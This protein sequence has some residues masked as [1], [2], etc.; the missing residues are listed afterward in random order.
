[1]LRQTAMVT[2]DCYNPLFGKRF[3]ALAFL[4][5]VLNRADGLPTASRH[6][7]VGVLRH[8]ESN[9]VE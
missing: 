2:R 1:M 7:D 4:R 9:L 3:D 6:R 5:V 8:N